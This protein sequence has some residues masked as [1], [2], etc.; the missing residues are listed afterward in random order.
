MF[1]L[2]DI[3]GNFVG[4]TIFNKNILLV[5]KKNDDGSEKLSKLI[6]FSTDNKPGIDGNRLLGSPA[7]LAIEEFPINLRW[8]M[9]L[10]LSQFE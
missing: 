9:T 2:A 3:K 4:N 6:Y 5:S 1:Y 10:E 8:I 7:I